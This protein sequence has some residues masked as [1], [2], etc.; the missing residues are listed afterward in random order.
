MRG[1]K[2]TPDLIIAAGMSIAL[3]VA[4]SLGRS[5]EITGV[6]AGGLAGYLGQVVS[7][8]DSR[9]RAM[10]ERRMSDAKSENR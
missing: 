5:P 9:K 1:I 3:I 2:I 8:D 7:N 10:E 4:V 6:I